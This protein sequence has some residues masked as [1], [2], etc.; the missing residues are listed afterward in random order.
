[1]VEQILTD[2]KTP[3]LRQPPRVEQA[4]GVTVTGIIAIIVS[5]QTSM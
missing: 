5:M 3:A 4:F 1:M 2:L